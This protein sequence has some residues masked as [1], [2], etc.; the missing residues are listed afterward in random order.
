ML[1]WTIDFESLPTLAKYMR[2]NTHLWRFY[3]HL[4]FLY[5]VK[6]KF[7]YIVNMMSLMI[8]LGIKF[9]MYTHTY[10]YI[11][12]YTDMYYKYTYKILTKTSI[13]RH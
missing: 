11:H 12:S 8:K 10:I 4:L 3:Y 1:H 9:Y 5:I 2:E 13:N 6:L 7:W